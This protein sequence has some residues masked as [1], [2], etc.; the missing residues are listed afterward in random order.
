MAWLDCCFGGILPTLQHVV[1][2]GHTTTH[3]W[4]ELA[5][6]LLLNQR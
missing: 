2:R 1:G 3:R 6:Q 5:Y 4:K